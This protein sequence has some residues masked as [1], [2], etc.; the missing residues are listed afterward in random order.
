M[1]GTYFFQ[2]QTF[3]NEVEGSLKNEIKPTYSDRIQHYF[4]ETN[5]RK[6]AMTLLV[7]LNLM[8]FLYLILD[9]KN[10]ANVPLVQKPYSFYSIA[11]HSGINA[12]IFSL[13]LVIILITYLFRGAL[14][15]TGNRIVKSLAV[16]WIILN[17]VLVFTTALK[18][19]DYISQ[20]GFT[21]KRLGVYLY[22]LLCLVGLSFALYKI[23]RTLSIWFLIRNMSVTFLAVFSLVSLFNWDK[24]ITKY[25][26]TFVAKEQLDLEYLYQL[27]P[28]SYPD[29]MKYHIEQKI[30]D[31]DLVYR[32]S[33]SITY[34]V[35]E[36]KRFFSEKSWRSYVYYDLELYNQLKNY[37][38]IYPDGVSE[39]EL[40]VANW[41]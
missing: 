32:L 29:L 13:V 18:N 40:Q 23:F 1:Y 17:C 6:L 21:Y 16:V 30:V 15:F 37:H 34:E 24:I 28:D 8:L 38:F 5:E 31:T 36:L 4:G 41:R 2:P 27:G 10:L 26:L 25:N 3:I 35:Q 7:I 11:I 33:T 14:N 39:E 19:H 20:L 12:L 22:L 9:I